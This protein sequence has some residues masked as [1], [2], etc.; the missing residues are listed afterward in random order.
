MAGKKLAKLDTTLQFGSRVSGCDSGADPVKLQ[1][2]A[3]LTALEGLEQAGL[4]EVKVTQR[5]CLYPGI[6]GAAIEGTLDGDIS[7][8]NGLVGY[9]GTQ[10]GFISRLGASYEG[11]AQ[12]RLPGPDPEG[13][14][15]VS[16][17]GI[18]GC[19]D[20]GNFLEAGFGYRWGEGVPEAFEGCDLAPFR[21]PAAASG[22]TVRSAGAADAAP[23]RRAA[24][25]RCRRQGG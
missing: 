24:A 4:A 12:V 3:D 9:K 10:T 1:G 20:V 16:S 5:H 14:A 11:S 8:A 23:P 6:E 18:A 13:S 7:F 2:E 22:A 25:R 19:A 17:V 21:V 15:I